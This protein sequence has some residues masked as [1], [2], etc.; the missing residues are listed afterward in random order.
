M[1][2]AFSTVVG[3]AY[4]MWLFDCLVRWEYDHH[5]DQWEAHGRPRGFYWKP[6][7]RSSTWAQQWLGLVWTW[8]APKWILEN[9]SASRW[10]LQYRIIGVAS[11]A[12]ILGFLYFAHRTTNFIH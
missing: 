4:A 2:L 1:M 7:E 3:I 11:Q 5:R 8:K 9:P 6:Q 10:L 12:A